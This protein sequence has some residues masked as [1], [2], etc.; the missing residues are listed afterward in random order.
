[1]KETESIDDFNG[2]LSEISSKSAALG[3]NIDGPKLVKKFLKSLSRKKYIHIVASLEH[4]LDLNTT[5]FEEIVGRLKAY[6]ERITEDEETRDDQSKLMYANMEAQSGQSNKSYGQ[7]NRD[8]NGDW[9]Y[10]GRGGGCFYCRGRGRGRYYGG[11]DTR[12]AS[13]ITCFRCD[14]VGHFVASCPELKLKLQEAQEDNTET[15]EAD[16]G[17]GKVLVCDMKK[18]LETTLC[19]VLVFLM[20]QLSCLSL[21]T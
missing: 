7:Q 16:D 2:K 20:V 9:R 10:R 19:S 21:N 5:T 15:Q 4:V 3:S 13:K 8:Y 1:M 6:E 11:K 17:D 14:K 12:D 18:H